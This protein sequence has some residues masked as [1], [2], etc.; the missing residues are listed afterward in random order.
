[1]NVLTFDANARMVAA[2]VTQIALFGSVTGAG[3]SVLLI[4]WLT[5]DGPSGFTHRG[6]SD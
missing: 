5:V 1:M 6:A 3:M 2:T 4:P